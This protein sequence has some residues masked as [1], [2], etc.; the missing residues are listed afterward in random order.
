MELEEQIA[1]LTARVE[2]L[3][4]QLRALGVDRAQAAPPAPQAGLA[5]AQPTGQPAPGSPPTAGPLGPE[6][7]ITGPMS[8]QA[9]P[10]GYQTAG[11]PPPIHTPSG[12]QT[13]GPP[14]AKRPDWLTTE[15]L[16]KW[17]GVLLV[18]LAA[19]F[20]VGT[21]ISRGW[22]G[23]ELQLAGATV[24]GL[25]LIAGGFHLIDR[26]RPW[27]GALATG[28]AVVVSV[29][30]A[31]ANAGLDLIEDAPALVLLAV[32]TAG[33]YVVAIRLRVEA[34]ASAAGLAA[35]VLPLWIVE[36]VE[37]PAAVPA[38]WTVALV[39]VASVIGWDR[40]WIACRVLTVAVAALV[41]LG[42]IGSESADLTDLERILAVAAVAV[43]A[44]VAWAGP[45]VSEWLGR[46]IQ[47]TSWR[48]IDHRVVLSIPIW[49]W[50][51]TVLATD[52]DTDRSVAV[53]GL[54]LTVAFVALAL[55]T[56]SRL[57][58]STAA[59]H[60]LGAG[61]LLAVSMAVLTD[62]P[63]LLVGLAAQAAATAAIGWLLRDRWLLALAAFLALIA[64]TW[65]ATSTLAGLFD[66]VSFG[67][68]LANLFVVVLLVGAAALHWR[69]FDDRLSVLLI[70]VAWVGTLGWIASAFGHG[71]GGQGQVIVS[72]LW[73]ILAAA[74]LVIGVRADQQIGRTIGIVTLGVVL[75]K[76]LTVDLAEVD[77]LWRVGLFL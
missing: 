36:D 70:V 58:S 49:A 28:G 30:A 74:A 11:P 46:T 62:G 61:I 10:S 21:A 16:L 63:G 54:G 75:V 51:A 39:V 35:A 14:P 40:G 23:P 33:L 76:L 57:V 17:S 50:G 24:G 64:V 32:V 3:E 42:L 68:L 73:S 71:A 37:I 41:L 8:G 9:A 45:S 59:A 48:G 29:C 1:A 65:A 72:L 44:L 26:N 55:A 22:I 5:A 34:V 53:T 66:P 19:V 4:F 38:G 47:T 25:A 13:A 2:A 52:L 31:A 27:A 60:L 56:W 20:F 77:T 15:T 67:Q 69:A 6:S 12:Y 18:V 43:T 7:P